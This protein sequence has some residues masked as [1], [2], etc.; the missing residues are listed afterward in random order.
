M[1]V[2]LPSW[3]VSLFLLLDCHPGPCW[4]DLS[5]F[6][7]LRSPP[8]ALPT[9][10]KVESGTSQ[11]KIGTSVKLSNS[12]LLWTQ[13][14]ERLAEE[15]AGGTPSNADSSPKSGGST[16]GRGDSSQKA[17]GGTM[18]S[19]ESSSK[20]GGATKSSGDSGKTSGKGDEL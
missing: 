12:G 17:G 3:L 20:S 14:A 16:K 10:A 7:S 8:T 4:R 2:A 1:G 11:S 13:H 6:D 5:P 19:G 9:E 18:S 15:A